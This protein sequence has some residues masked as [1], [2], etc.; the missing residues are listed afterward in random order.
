MPNATMG[1]PSMSIGLVGLKMAGGLLF[2]LA[3]ILLAFWGIKRF[4]P[5]AGLRFPGQGD[6]ELLG[7]L[8]LGPKRSLAVVR[9]LNKKVLIGVT[10]SS[11]TTLTEIQADHETPPEETFA[12]L[13]EHAGPEPDHGGADPDTDNSAGT[14]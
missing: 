2:L 3:L 5:R 9:F 12:S 1:D 10:E 11:I 7:Q 4:G 14:G 8:S 6:L 13:L